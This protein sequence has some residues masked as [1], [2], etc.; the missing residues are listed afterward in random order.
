MQHSPTQ[1]IFTWYVVVSKRVSKNISFHLQN[2]W[3][4]ED[5]SV[6]KICISTVFFYFTSFFSFHHYIIIFYMVI[7][8]RKGTPKDNFLGIIGDVFKA[9]DLITHSIFLFK[10]LS[11][12]SLRLCNNNSSSS[13]SLCIWKLFFKYYVCLK[14]SNRR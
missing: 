3:I 6:I 11:W 14:F 10:H 1:H 13:S 12:A 9:L 7:T 4:N 8:A 5:F 2:L